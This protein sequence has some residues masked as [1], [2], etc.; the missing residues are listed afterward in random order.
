MKGLIM[1]EKKPLKRLSSYDINQKLIN[2]ENEGIYEFIETDLPEHLKL[3][4][5]ITKAHSK[6][7]IIN[8]ECVYKGGRCLN[9]WRIVKNRI[10]HGIKV[11]K[12][13][14]M[15]NKKKVKFKNPQEKSEYNKR[16]YD[17]SDIFE[18]EE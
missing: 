10:I 2:L 11:S 16:L 13:V 14:N 9:K 6:G 15:K 12:E 17:G 3:G 7:W 8:I 1:K 18:E 5:M 4:K